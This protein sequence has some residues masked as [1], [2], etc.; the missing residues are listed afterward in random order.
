MSTGASFSGLDAGGQRRVLRGM[1]RVGLSRFGLLGGRLKFLHSGEN[2]TFAF[3][4]DSDLS[5]LPAPYHRRRVLVRLHGSAFKSADWVRSETQWLSALRS[6]GLVVPEPLVSSDGRLVEQ[7]SFEGESRPCTLMRWIEGRGGRVVSVRRMYLTGRLMAKMH[8]QA[9]SWELPTGFERRNWDFDEF[10]GN[11]TNLAT[12]IEVLWSFVP[13]VLVGPM[14]DMED[15]FHDLYPAEVPSDRPYGLVHADLHTWNTVMHKGEV[16]PID[17]DDCGFAYHIMDI[18]NVL[19]QPLGKP[20]WYERASSFISGYREV[21]P[22]PESEW[23]KV[24]LAMAM[25]CASNV[26]WLIDKA[27][28]NALYR[29]KLDEWMEDDRLALVEAQKIDIGFTGG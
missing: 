20:G 26:L 2:A 25:R 10:F 23:R 19:E 11:T 27:Q 12:P 14:R 5:P 8:S 15:R 16:Y 29:E 7:V 9:C 28:T 3:D 21:R 13:K 1:A 4:S 18:A 24:G 17:F 6:S 22:F